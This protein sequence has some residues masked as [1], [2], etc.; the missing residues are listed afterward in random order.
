MKSPGRIMQLEIE[1][2]ALRKE[3][4][5][6]EGRLE[7]LEKGTGRLKEEKTRVVALAA[8]EGTDPGGRKVK[9]ELEQVRL[10]MQRTRR[11]ATTQRVRA[12]VRPHSQMERET[13]TRDEAGRAGSRAAHAEGGRSTKEDIAEVVSR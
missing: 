3:S 5:G 1:R 12:S 2:E 8:G 13:R 10:E 4:T 9:E 6:L 11:P 7:K